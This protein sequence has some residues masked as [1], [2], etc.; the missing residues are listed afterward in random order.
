MS[1]SECPTGVFNDF[2]PQGAAIPQTHTKRGYLTFDT[3]LAVLG[4]KA[5]V[6]DIHAALHVP[7]PSPAWANA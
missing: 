1:N 6:F 5:L 3:Y 7:A 2:V 4:E